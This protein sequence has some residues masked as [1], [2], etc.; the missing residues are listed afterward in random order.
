M[1]AAYYPYTMLGIKARDL[2]GTIFTEGTDIIKYQ[3][4]YFDELIFDENG[5]PLMGEAKLEFIT[6]NDYKFLC[7][8]FFFGNTD[9]RGYKNNLDDYIK[10]NYNLDLIY[11]CEY[12]LDK[13][14]ILGMILSDCNINGLDIGELFDLRKECEKRFKKLNLNV[15]PKLFTAF[16]LSI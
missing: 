7:R 3:R 14:A 6:F 5:K 4:K 16:H 10:D 1:G 15:E 12:P 13:T 9:I 2:I 11:F 8:D